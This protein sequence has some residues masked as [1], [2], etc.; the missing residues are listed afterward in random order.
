M[1][2]TL[3]SMGEQ[4][5]LIFFGWFLGLFTP[6]VYIPI[7]R[8]W[9]KWR[10]HRDEREPGAALDSLGF[11]T[12][13]SWSPY[14]Q[15]ERS[16]VDV[17]LSSEDW[18][19]TWVPQEL[20]DEALVSILDTGGP[21]SSLRSLKVDHRESNQGMK[22]SLSYAKSE[23]KDFIAVG[24][25]F[26]SDADRT[27]RLMQ[28]LHSDNAADMV[29]GS[30]RSVTAMNV[31]VLSEDLLLLV[32]RRSAAVRTSQNE[33][34]LGP[35]ETMLGPGE[36]QQV[37]GVEGPF[38]LAE[39]CLKEELG[40][41]LDDVSFLGISWVG[42][43]VPGAI[44]HW[45]AHTKIRL[46]SDEITRRIR[47]SHGGFE[48]DAIGWMKFDHNALDEIRQ[49]SEDRKLDSQ[50][51]YWNRTAGLAA[52]DIRRWKSRLLAG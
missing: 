34:T 16:N 5:P 44:C 27:A 28:R 36:Q 40:V 7:R 26:E 41:G 35:N 50:S 32:L 20:L 6:L 10:A 2:L 46:R 11:F 39:R 15:L 52:Q 19:Q 30:P 48:V 45:L 42:Y 17:T 13:N 25:L 21:S 14:R 38:Q 9:I 12:L 23:Y 22:L 49:R 8:I 4:I 31:T 24:K 47:E 37:G 33:W 29:A 51:R 18:N 43:N 1:L 3:R